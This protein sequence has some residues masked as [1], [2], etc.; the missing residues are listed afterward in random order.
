MSMC[1]QY[2]EEEMCDITNDIHA[3]YGLE[4][5]IR[6]QTSKGV[7]ADAAPADLIADLCHL[8]RRSGMDPFKEV[9]RALRNFM[10][11]ESSLEN[12]SA[13]SF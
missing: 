6:Y 3:D 2:E 1:G 10:D 11:E 9:D 5:V 8:M 7:D 12:K 13:D 4:A